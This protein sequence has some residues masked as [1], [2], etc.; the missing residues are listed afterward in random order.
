M[1]E[2]IR[3]FASLRMTGWGNP[4]N[5][6][7][8]VVIKS[9]EILL[10]E[11]HPSAALSLFSTPLRSFPFGCSSAAPG[12]G[13]SLFIAVFRLICHKQTISF[14]WTGNEHRFQTP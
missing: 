14:V 11:A 7:S 2:E 1:S 4:P 12:L 5:G 3:F 6:K 13:V 10:R 8:T 9:F